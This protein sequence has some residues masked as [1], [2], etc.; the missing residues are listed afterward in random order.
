M[1]REQRSVAVATIILASLFVSAHAMHALGLRI[2]T[3][4]SEPMGL[5]WMQPYQGTVGRGD[6]IEFCPAIQ[7]KDFP[8]TLKG[9][10]PGGTQPFLKTVIGVPGDFVQTSDAGVRINHDFIADSRPK[11]HSTTSP[12]PL[13]HWKGERLLGRDEY[14]AYGAANPQNSFDSRYYGPITARQ[15]MSIRKVP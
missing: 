7:Q 15:I 2:N 9:D 10:C 8:F 11:D 6:L 4:A 1:T 5:Y 12:T 3:S 14:W 13:P